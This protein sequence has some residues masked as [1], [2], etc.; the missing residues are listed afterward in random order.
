ML[1]TLNRIVYKAANLAEAREW[2]TKILG[3][4]P[5]YDSPFMV[6]FNSEPACAAGG[7]PSAWPNG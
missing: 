1:K 4:H 3:T 6:I 2:Y 5:I 7:R